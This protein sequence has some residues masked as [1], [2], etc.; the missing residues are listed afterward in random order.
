MPINNNTYVATALHPWLLWQTWV[1]CSV[2]MAGLSMGLIPLATFGYIWGCFPPLQ[3]LVV[4]LSLQCAP[5][6]RE[7]MS[8]TLSQGWEAVFKI[9]HLVSSFL[10]QNQVSSRNHAFLAECSFQTCTLPLTMQAFSR[11]HEILRLQRWW[12]SCPVWFSLLR[13]ASFCLLGVGRRDPEH[14]AEPWQALTCEIP[15]LLPADPCSWIL[16]LFFFLY[17]TVSNESKLK[18]QMVFIFLF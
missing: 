15:H 6:H 5:Q 11:S 18:E 13:A 2:W 16:V 9:C 14:M 10:P 8:C 12:P 17:R 1:F 4:W 3:S 7:P